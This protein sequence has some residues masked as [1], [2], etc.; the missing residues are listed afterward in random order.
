MAFS[1]RPVSLLKSLFGYGSGREPEYIDPSKVATMEADGSFASAYAASMELKSDR[2]GMY[3]EMETMDED[4]IVECVLDLI[5]EDCTQQDLVTNKT[6]W[7]GSSN[8]KIVKIGNDLF[9]DLGMEDEI[10][11]ITR[12]MAKYGDIF[13]S[14]IQ[15]KKD[16]KT[17]GE[18]KVL[19]Y[20][21]PKGV[22]RHQDQFGKLLG[23][24]LGDE[25][26]DSQMTPPWSMVHFRL[27]GKK[28]SNIK[29]ADEGYG[30]AYL[31]PARRI[32]R[33][34]K[35]MEDALA[36]YR[37][38]RCPDRFKFALK[39]LDA[40]APEERRA[41]LNKIRQDLRKKVLIDPATGS[42]RSE[43]DPMCFTG[44]T[45][46]SL[47]DGREVS[48]KDLADEYGVRDKEFWVYSYDVE[49]NRIVPG[50]AVHLGVTGKCVKKLVEVEIDNGE[51][52]RCTPNHRWLMRDGSYKVAEELGVGDSLMPLY[53]IQGSNDKY[54]MVK[55][56]SSGKYVFTHRMSVGYPSDDL[57][58]HHCDFN[59][60]NNNPTNL[61]SM[62]WP[63]HT[64]LH[65]RIGGNGFRERW[66]EQEF[67][68]M[69]AKRFSD[70]WKEPEFRSKMCEAASVRMIAYNKSEAHSK[71]ATESNKR[72][73]EE[74]S[75]YLTEYN[76]SD[77]HRE[78]A[79]NNMKVLWADPVRR[80]GMIKSRA[81]ARERKVLEKAEALVA[82]NHKVKSIRLVDVC[83]DVYD[84][85]VEEYHNFALTAGVFVHNSIDEDY[86]YDPDAVDIDKI[87]G[88]STVGHVLDVEY[89]RKRFFSCIK[90]PPDYLGFSDARGGFLSASPLSHQDV[91]FARQCK[92]IKRSVG[93]GLT[94]LLQI[95]LCWCGIDPEL[96]ENEFTIESV[97]VSYLEEIQR[98]QLYE[99]R[100]KVLAIME[101][102]GNALGFDREAFLPYLVR[103][104]GLPKSLLNVDTPKDGQVL[105]TGDLMDARKAHT[106]SQIFESDELKAELAG[107]VAEAC[108]EV[109]G[110][111]RPIDKI[112]S[113]QTMK[114]LEPLPI[115]MET[116]NPL[117]MEWAKKQEK[118]Y[119]LE[120]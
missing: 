98:A 4:D 57:C 10:F 27:L 35:M 33:R 75:G 24:N 22:H 91:Q 52:L 1:I 62:G 87:Q 51:I 41:M 107:R 92:R 106:I 6:V 97:P 48:L 81:E 45:K 47:L 79:R 103:V 83:E 96:P 38:K 14:L 104:A 37:I 56:I 9:D 61:E 32:Y 102:I 18:V 99:V 112:S 115:P 23:F 49:N 40:F 116:G 88:S 73:S 66:K 55:D 2:I 68:D 69:V 109:L 46:I 43:V 94:R 31:A 44:D 36:I 59:P 108:Y 39:G 85:Q 12:A 120:D 3:E 30:Y 53:R 101:D 71:S 72:R 17:P 11:S 105:V 60:L 118:G 13:Y 74:L 26:S 34:W 20:R 82:N 100:A 93:L 54:E 50:K 119:M 78:T 21:N 64:R 63:D 84:I 110:E 67:R 28:G 42:V 19:K 114:W 95:N 7:I 117:V 80:A 70:L 113:R 77:K 5:S 15:A 8:P 25:L 16:D 90:V 86:F 65:K 111:G 58:V 29:Y 89:M 76:K